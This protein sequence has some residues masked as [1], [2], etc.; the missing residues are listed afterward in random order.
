MK[1]AFLNYIIILFLSACDTSGERGENEEKAMQQDND[2]ALYN[3]SQE[4][5]NGVGRHFYY[6]H[7]AKMED[8][9]SNNAKG[10]L[11]AAAVIENHKS[12]TSQTSL[13][14]IFISY[15][16]GYEKYLQQLSNHVSKASIPVQTPLNQMT[17]EVLKT[18]KLTQN[19][20][21]SLDLK[22]IF[23]EGNPAL[24]AKGAFLLNLFGDKVS[25]KHARYL[26]LHQRELTEPF[27]EDAALK[28]SF[29][30]V[31]KRLREWLNYYNQFEDSPFRIEA[32]K[33]LNQ[34]TQAFFIGLNNTPVFSYDGKREINPQARQALK[35]YATS[36]PNT[37]PG[38][39]AKEYLRIIDAC[40]N[41]FCEKSLEFYNK[42]I[43]D[44]YKAD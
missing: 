25:E 12:K 34:Y 32:A 9:L 16:D 26:T 27:A 14:S 28:I 43:A 41:T 10:L 13:D 19:E 35:A 17:R 23:P 44:Y 3:S 30:E 1:P 24:T 21:D 37:K 40:G 7:Y 29:K 42:Q 11:H 18:L 8:T 33:K 38:Q 6:S 39:W 15:Q 4:P 2:S 36:Y 22:I 31:G 5:V 20:F